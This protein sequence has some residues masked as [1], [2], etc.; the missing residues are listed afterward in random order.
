MLRLADAAGLTMEKLDL[1]EGRPEYMRILCPLYIIGILYER[2]VN[3]F[4]T[5]A[6]FRVLLIGVLSKPS[7]ETSTSA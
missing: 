1:I 4:E 7:T 3:R 6:R 2:L 5:L